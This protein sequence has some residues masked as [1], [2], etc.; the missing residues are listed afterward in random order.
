M[1]YA[2]LGSEPEDTTRYPRLLSE[3]ALA[4]IALCFLLGPAR[5]DPFIIGPL[6]ALYAMREGDRR[7]MVLY[8]VLSS[9]S[10]PF[11][12]IY[13][14]SAAAALARLGTV[15]AIIL[16]IALLFLALKVHDTLPSA[17]PDRADPAKLQA[18]VQEIVERTLREV[19]D[20]EET[21]QDPLDALP[22]PSA[23]PAAPPAA[24]LPPKTAQVRSQAVPTIGSSA[25]SG[26]G[27]DAS[28][29][30]V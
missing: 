24:A 19:L 6:A 29:E 9:S 26:T 12:L 18:T 5:A 1:V 7:A 11:D 10:I 20:Q 3:G 30:E 13:M 2:E 27:T 15:V 25:V 8:M 23:M 4:Q 28:W 16:K 22:T 17:R 21:A 14:S